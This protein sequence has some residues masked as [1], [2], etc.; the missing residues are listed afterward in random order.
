MGRQFGTLDRRSLAAAEAEVAGWLRANSPADAT[1]LAAPRIAYLAGRPVLPLDVAALP[2][3]D[4]GETF[5]AV[6]DAPPD[7]VVSDR[8]IRWDAFTRSG[9]FQERYAPSHEVTHGYSHVTPLTIWRYQPSPFDAGSPQK[10]LARVD[11]QFEVTGYQVEPPVFTPG[12]DIAVSLFL[13]ATAPLANG[14]I[15]GVQLVAPDGRIW[16]WREEQTPRSLSGTWWEPGQIITERYLIPTTGDLP[17]GAYSVEAFWRAADDDDRQLPVLQ[18]ED[19]NVLDRIK[20]G[21]V[22]VPQAPPAVDTFPVHARFGEEIVLVEAALGEAAPG[23]RLAVTLI[24]EALS[25][26]ADD[27]TVF[28]HLLDETG[29]LVAGDDGKP[30]AGRFPTLAWRPGTTVTDRHELP[31]PAELPAGDYQV[32]V[33]LYQLESGER[34]PVSDANGVEPADRALSLGRITVSEGGG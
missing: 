32:K 22:I 24:W 31:L 4:S 7:F 21:Y 29:A 20:L 15:T 2:P 18:G 13:R 1:L 28:V 25:L 26:P 17:S 12:E 14:F 16:A 10:V 3:G 30:G 5:T 6:L 27:Y 19:D 9:W 33:G 34:L 8:S 23:E 11:S